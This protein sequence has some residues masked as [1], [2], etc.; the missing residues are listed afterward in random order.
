M[1]TLPWPAIVGKARP[2]L[3]IGIAI[4]D[5]RSVCR[6]NDMGI[7]WT[8]VLGF[9]IGVIAKLVH[10][11]RENMGFFM[12]VLLGIAGSFLAGVIG[13]FLGW[14]TA[15]EGAGFIASVIVAILLLVIYGKLRG[16]S[17][18]DSPK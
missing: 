8:I 16:G 4:S 6:G 12:T 2:V 3:G 10:P 7:I 9:V 14:Y 11:G 13:Q 18:P 15:G 1:P 17:S 5:N